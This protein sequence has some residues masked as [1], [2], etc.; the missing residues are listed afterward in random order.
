MRRLLEH[1]AALPEMG[2]TSAAFYLPGF[3]LSQPT[4]MH[5]N[6]PCAVT[7]SSVWCP[8]LLLVGLFCTPPLAVPSRP[9]MCFFF[10]FSGGFRLPH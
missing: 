2:L 8:V 9:L 3:D 7:Q 6:E 1:D 4:R 5:K 10:F